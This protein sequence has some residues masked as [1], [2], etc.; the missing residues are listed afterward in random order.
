MIAPRMEARD[1][2]AELLAR[3]LYAEAGERPARAIEALA[4]LACNRARAVRACP[5][6]ARRRPAPRAQ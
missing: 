6:A 4:S 5:K 2:A 1:V 3:V